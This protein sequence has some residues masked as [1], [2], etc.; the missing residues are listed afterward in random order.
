MVPSIR[1]S[2]SSGDAF[3]RNDTVSKFAR[4]RRRKP[5][6]SA[7]N[8]RDEDL[9]RQAD[10]EEV[11]GDPVSKIMYEGPDS[12]SDDYSWVDY[13]P[14]QI[15][16]ATAR[17]YGRVAIIVFKVKDR[18]KR[19]IKGR[20]P[21]KYHSIEVQNLALVSALA[22]ILKKQDCYISETETVIFEAPFHVPFF[23]QDEIKQLYAG[24]ATDDELAPYLR[25]LV[26]TMDLVLGDI[27][28]KLNNLGGSGLI[29]FATVWTLFP[30]G[31]IV[32]STDL[33]SEFLC[34]VIKADYISLSTGEQCL[35]IGVKVIRF[36][37]ESFVWTTKMLRLNSFSGNKP[38]KQLRHYPVE[39][40]N[41]MA[42]VY[43]RL[44]H[45]GKVMLDLQSQQ[46]RSY[47]NV[48]VY[49]Q[50]GETSKKHNVEGR[51][52]VHV[53][54]YQKYQDDSLHRSSTNR[55]S[56]KRRSEDED[57][58]DYWGIGAWDEFNNDYDVP[59]ADANQPENDTLLKRITE[60]Q[61]QR[62]KEMM[63]RREDDLPFLY[64]L[65]GGFEL[66]TKLWV[67][68]YIED[69]EP[70]I[71]NDT[72]YSHLV[73]DEQQKD[74]ILSFVQH[75][76]FASATPAPVSFASRSPPNDPSSA[77]TEALS[78]K[79]PKRTLA[80]IEDVIIGKGQGPVAD[81]TRRPL[82]S[83]QADNLGT[84]ANTLGT[85]LRYYLTMAA[86]LN[87]VVLLDEAD[88]FMA[89]RDPGN[90]HRNELVSIFLRELEYF[91]GILF[92]TTN[93]YETI[94]SAFR[95]RVSLHLR[96]PALSRDARRKVWHNFLSRLAPQTLESA[97]PGGKGNTVLL[98]AAEDDDDDDDDDQKV[99]G[100]KSVVVPT[101]SEADINE[102]SLWQ[103]NGREI[104]NTVK[105]V[106]MWCD[107]KG[108]AMTL[109]KLESGICATN[110][111]AIKGVEEDQELYK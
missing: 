59:D 1:S 9:P 39:H 10:E 13:P 52:F 85:N 24:L 56:S 69:I 17:E 89:E 106:R 81:L 38:I 43:D 49:W 87:A 55:K 91:R 63:L 98:A 21:L 68:F 32:Y 71:W 73:Y 80:P 72:A 20:R 76:S 110:P 96:F 50:D 25:L 65:V 53:S 101:V 5:L 42:G 88:V 48:A 3:L 35:E 36:N 12:Y 94:D 108:Y 82:L 14:K 86:D 23:C 28:T 19:C 41:D 40:H 54:G 103:L 90:V 66:K 33:E 60:S 51:I 8:D 109:D 22:S 70:I 6:G 11:G 61:C 79:T 83:L 99:D 102:L 74:L 75:R 67:E 2:D 78:G 27:H 29:S 100:D 16:K 47:N 37:G 31:A 30:R 46:Y 107:H 64:G 58:L 111:S 104:K 4:K 62:N 34:K 7:D 18:E 105:L 57:D 93:L 95:S 84:Q 77:A 97:R 92:L 45:R 15:S 44:Q 26:N